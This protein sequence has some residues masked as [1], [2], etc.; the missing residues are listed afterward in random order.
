[1]CSSDL[2][3]YAISKLTVDYWVKENL[4]RFKAPVVGLRYFNVYGADEKK[5]DFC[6]SPVYRFSEQAKSTGVIKIFEGSEKTY[7]DFVCVE[8]VVKLTA[9]LYHCHGTYDVGC[10]TSISFLD[11]AVMVAKKYNATIQFIPFPEVI[12]GKYQKYSIARPHFPDHKFVQVSEFV[13]RM[14]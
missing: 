12:K 11:V 3:Y 10:G 13:Q 9:N 7:R 2:N 6:T 4:S 1:M 14:D 5:D 8:D